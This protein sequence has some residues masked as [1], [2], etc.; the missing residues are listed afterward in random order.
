MVLLKQ[1]EGLGEGMTTLVNELDQANET[2]W[3]SPCTTNKASY[4]EKGWYL[5]IW[6]RWSVE[7]D[8]FF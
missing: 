5:Y 3:A 6:T 2:I 7:Q 4:L 8:R 1:V